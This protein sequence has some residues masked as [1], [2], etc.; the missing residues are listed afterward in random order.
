[1]VVV[2]RTGHYRINKVTKQ[3]ALRARLDYR[4]E[5]LKKGI[6]GL[7]GRTSTYAAR[8]WIKKNRQNWLK[9]DDL[10]LLRLCR[11]MCR[12]DVALVD[13]SKR[14]VSD[15]Q[16]AIARSCITQ[17]PPKNP[18]RMLTKE[19]EAWSRTSSAN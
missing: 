5:M 14:P 7:C 2:T 13:E 12:P 15:R 11:M 4:T 9:F 17:S 1:M 3:D 8:R 19:D 6:R 10:T 16:V 18:F